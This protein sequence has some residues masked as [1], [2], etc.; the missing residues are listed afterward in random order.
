MLEILSPYYAISFPGSFEIL[1]I[2]VVLA[3]LFFWIKTLVEIARSSFNDN[4]QQV[5][6]ILVVAFCGLVGMI[7]YYA[8]GRKNRILVSK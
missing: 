2:L 4:T 5:I 8:V 6:W 1:I 7:I 3:Y